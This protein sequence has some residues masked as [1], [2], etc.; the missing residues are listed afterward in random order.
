MQCKFSMDLQFCLSEEHFSLDILA[1]K[2]SELFEAKAFAQILRLVLMLS[3]EVLVMRLLKGK[4]PT[5]VAAGITGCSTATSTAASA[6]GSA[7]WNFRSGASV[8][9]SAVGR[10]RRSSV[11]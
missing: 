1:L 8:A 11:C 5:A 6:L 2:L 10:I 4:E 3:Q 9:V 7:R